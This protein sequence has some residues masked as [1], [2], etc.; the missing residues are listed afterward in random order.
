MNG[1]WPL[2]ADVGDL[3][4]FLIFLLFLI[5]SVVG[6]LANK[7]R[8]MQEEAAR[9]ARQPRPQRPPRQPRPLDDEIADFL[10]TAGER[11]EGGKPRPSGGPPGAPPPRPAATRPSQPPTPPP[12]PR[13]EEPLEVKPLETGPR[14]LA[15]ELA[16]RTLTSGSLG[17]LSSDVAQADDR[18]ESRLRQTFAHDLSTLSAKP[19]VS[20]SSPAEPA[21]PLPPTAAAGLTALLASGANLRNA[22]ILSEIINRPEHRWQ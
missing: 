10:R 3:I 12:R 21:T 2:I 8:Q 11:R 5:I 22:V 7:W 18:L 4:G 1:P 19:S 15:E 6:S 20:P 13:T 16:T 17:H 14:R 9:R